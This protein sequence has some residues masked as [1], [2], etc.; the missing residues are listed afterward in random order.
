M[1]KEIVQTAEISSKR[2]G[3]GRFLKG[4]S[5]NPVGR[6]KGQY[7]ESTK[8]FMA[9]KEIAAKHADRAF[10]MVWDAMENKEAWAF[11]IYFKELFHL[12][13]NYGQKTVILEKE[14]RSVDGQIKV[15]TEALPEFDEVTQSE[16]LERLK[17]LNSLKHTDKV[18]L[19]NETL[20]EST[21]ALKERVVLLKT[22]MESKDKV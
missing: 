6:V 3:R 16:S 21:E 9:V 20:I 19:E 12:P 1:N 5:G 4:K 18:E 15:I 22:L 10:K 7:P 2:D 14:E 13:K 17:V 11:Q 8:K